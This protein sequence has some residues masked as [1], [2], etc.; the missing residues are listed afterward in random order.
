MGAER[1]AQFARL[2]ATGRTRCFGVDSRRREQPLPPRMERKQPTAQFA[3]DECWGG[4]SEIALAKVL[5]V[6]RGAQQCG[7]ERIRE[8]EGGRKP[9]GSHPP[10]SFTMG[11][12]P[13]LNAC[14]V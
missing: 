2:D 8:R 5:A 11:T 13:A 14:Q 6:V 4:R 7:P 1:G 10:M 9:I 12:P 3:D